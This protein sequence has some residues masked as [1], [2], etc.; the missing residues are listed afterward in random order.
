MADGSLWRSPAPGWAHAPWPQGEQLAQGGALMVSLGQTFR[1]PCQ[2]HIKQ[3]S[4]TAAEAVGRAGQWLTG[5]VAL[6]LV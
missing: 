6:S 1:V 3:D 4:H 5:L 2:L